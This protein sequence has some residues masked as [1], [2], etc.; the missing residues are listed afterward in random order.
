MLGLPTE[1]T[2][3]AKLN[4]VKMDMAHG[5]P[6]LRAK[7]FIRRKLVVEL[8]GLAKQESAQLSAMLYCFSYKFL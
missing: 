8:M 5:T 1:A 6:P 7:C 3:D 4:K 2:H